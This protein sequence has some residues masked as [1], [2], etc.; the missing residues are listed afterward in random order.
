MLLEVKKCSN[1]RFKKTDERSIY[2]N[3]DLQGFSKGPI[4]SRLIDMKGNAWRLSV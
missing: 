4:G 3:T 1:K 2:K